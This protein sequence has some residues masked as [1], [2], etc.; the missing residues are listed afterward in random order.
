MH[1][2]RTYNLRLLKSILAQA[3]QYLSYI[4]QEPFQMG[5]A[6][7]MAHKLRS[8][9]TML[10]IIFGV[11][12]VIS[13]LAIGEGARQKTLAQIQAL[14]LNNIIVQQKPV[15]EY[16]GRNTE[17]ISELTL[18][19]IE[20]LRNIV[21]TQDGI[22]P[23]IERKREANYKTRLQ[24][25]TL[26]GTHSSYFELMHLK[27]NQGNFFSQLD[28]QH[29][30]RVCVL[31]A[32]ITQ[33]LFPAENPLGRWIKID[34][35]WL[36]V[37]GILDYQ[38]V[39]SAGAKQLDLN[40]HVFIPFHTMRIRF[41]RNRDESPLNQIILRISH[42][43]KVLASAG[44]VDRILYRRH[45]E[46]RDYT[47]IVP[48]QLLQQSEDTQRMFNIVMGAIAGISLL[49]GGIGIMNIML[50][51]ILERTREIGIR[52]ALGAK[53]RDV[54]TQFLIEAVLLSLLG[55]IIGIIIGYMLTFGITSFSKWS[56][57]VTW[58]SVVLAFGVSSGVG[59]IFG[60]YPARKAAMLNPIDALRYE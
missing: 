52:R 24:E 27:I 3:K 53:K 23:V 37:V 42:Q 46:K 47:M 36:R 13:M 21:H 58:W 2:K 56:T 10:G 31:G 28:N 14:G 17:K 8:F 57:S 45:R 19:D 33:A 16:N 34:N 54:L 29:Y 15:P 22:V 9:L 43:D 7:I 11:A 41:G 50:A 4:D 60:Y 18:E 48:E 12:A 26:T 51:S 35:I 32:Q 5:L 25:V 1:N 38:P 20:S 44:L 49:V 6:G 40:N 30:Q 55:G 39:S 59:I